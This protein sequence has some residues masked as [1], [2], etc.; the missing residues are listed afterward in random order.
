MRVVFVSNYFNHHQRPLCEA[1]SG[2]DGVD[3]CFYQTE[4][5]EEERVR[6]GWGID[7]AD[8]PYVKIFH[9]DIDATRKD[10]LESDIVI[11]GGVEME[12]EIEPRLQAGK[13]TFRYSERIYKEGWWKFISPRGLKKKYHDHIRYRKAPVY[14]LCAGAYVGADF[15]LIHAYPKKKF[16]WGYFPEVKHY[17][18]EE[19]MAKKSRDGE[20]VRILWAGRMIDWKHPE[21]AIDLADQLLHASDKEMGK[22][23]R[24]ELLGKLRDNGGFKITMAGGG[25]MEGAL[26]AEVKEKGLEEVVRFTG[27]LKPEE[28]RAEMERS[29]IFIFT[30]D[31]KEGWGAVLNEAMNSGCLVVARPGIGAVPY[32]VQHGHN[33]MVCTDTMLQFCGMVIWMALDRKDCHEQGKRAYETMV[34]YWNAENAAAQFLRVA[35]DLMEGKKPEYSPVEAG[36]GA[37]QPMCKDPEI[38]HGR[39]GRFTQRW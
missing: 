10:I 23:I 27:F 11:W 15:N 12:D 29:D 36:T 1:F 34:K 38:G 35:K 20:P 4:P 6:M 31:E 19:L 13:L 18:I 21:Y 16:V 9:D 22:C 8:Y 30:S 33:G 28:I 39:G 3:F 17:D 5:M 24:P 37:L 2:A 32:M 14:L 7:I 25:E 26:R